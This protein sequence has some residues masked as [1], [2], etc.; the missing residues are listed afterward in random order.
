MKHQRAIY[1]AAGEGVISC[2]VTTIFLASDPA[3]RQI[4]GRYFEQCQAVSSAP[5]TYDCQIQEA[6]W[7]K[8]AQL[9]GLEST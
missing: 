3:V 8:S 5:L 2:A 9:V 6:L 1:N 4:T 7:E